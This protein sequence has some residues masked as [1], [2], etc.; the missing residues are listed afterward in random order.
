MALADEVG[1]VN[2]QHIAGV[3]PF[4]GRGGMRLGRRCFGV[5]A[6]PHRWPWGGFVVAVGFVKTRQGIQRGSL[7]I[8]RRLELVLGRGGGGDR[9]GEGNRG[10]EGDF[11]GMGR[12]GQGFLKNR[13]EDAVH[14]SGTAEPDLDFRGVDVYIHFGG[15]YLEKEKDHGKPSGR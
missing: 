12:C 6:F 15:V 9:G 5:R 11:H 3:L 10:G 13:G 1:V 8:L 7:A 14:L 4:I 2:L